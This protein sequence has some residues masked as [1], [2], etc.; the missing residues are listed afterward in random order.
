[1]SNS[2]E[3]TRTTRDRSRQF[4][5]PWGQ[6]NCIGYVFYRMGIIPQEGY[7]EPSGVSLLDGLFERVSGL[8]DADAIAA[9]GDLNPGLK[10]GT[11]PMLFLSHMAVVDKA[12]RGYVSERAGAG[13]DVAHV[14]IEEAF[15]SYTQPH[16]PEYIHEL[17]YVRLIQPPETAE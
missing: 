8:D 9:V 16:R 10:Y 6:P 3:Q 12:Q 13:A 4:V 7:V 5:S 2:N 1:M 17:W 11:E 15:R 14:A